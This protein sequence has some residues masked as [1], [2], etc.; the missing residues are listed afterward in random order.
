MRPWLAKIGLVLGVLAAVF[1]ACEIGLRVFAPVG[2]MAPDKRE[3]QG[4]GWT[5]L[6]HVAT[7]R[8]CPTY[9]MAPNY[10]ATVRG[11]HVHTNSLGLRG[12]EPLPRSTP[13]L[14]RIAVLGDSMAF[15]MGVQQGED[16]PAQ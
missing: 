7:H 6:L 8:A 10:D 13:G 14:V 15:G 4:E 9:A 12:N 16:F 5:G 3:L 11:M 2:F 1:A